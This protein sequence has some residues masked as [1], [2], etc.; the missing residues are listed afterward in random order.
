M[1]VCQKII[2]SSLI[3]FWYSSGL[4]AQEPGVQNVQFIQRADKKVEVTYDLVGDPSQKYKVQLALSK[5]GSRGTIQINYA[6]RVI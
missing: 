6:Q 3:L 1:K 5:S 4:L 2:I